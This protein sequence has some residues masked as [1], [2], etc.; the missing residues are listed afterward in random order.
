MAKDLHTLIRLRAFEVDECR[1]SLGDL[2]RAEDVLIARQ[3]ALEAGYAKEVQFAQENPGFGQTLG[4]YIARY[5]ENKDQ[6]LQQRKALDAAIQVARDVLATAYKEL[7]TVELTQEN[8]DLE[9]QKERNRKEQ[10][11][12]D[13][14]GQDRHRRRKGKADLDAGPP[15]PS[16]RPTP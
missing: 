9:A 12:L 10:A 13:E 3:Q 11:F 4:A 15:P 1:R 14:L 5:A 6:L 7:K 16:R 8:R 2:L